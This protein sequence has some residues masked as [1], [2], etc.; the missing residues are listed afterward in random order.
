[1]IETLLLFAFLPTFLFLDSAINAL[2]DLRL[3]V[4]QAITLLTPIVVPFLVWAIRMVLPKIPR[5]ALPILAMGLGSAIQWL[6]T[7]AGNVADPVAGAL[8]GLA[9][10]GAREIVNTLQQHGT[11]A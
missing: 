2:P 8:L 4:A 7:L 9:A 6:S 3:S 5:V 1:M 11:S 10:V